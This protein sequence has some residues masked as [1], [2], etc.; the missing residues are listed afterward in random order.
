MFPPRERSMERTPARGTSLKSTHS[1]LAG[2]P[3]KAPAVGRRVRA[4]EAP[5]ASAWYTGP[6]CARARDRFPRHSCLEP[7]L[8]RL[9]RSFQLSRLTSSYMT[10]I[11]EA[12]LVL[13]EGF[14]MK[15][16]SGLKSGLPSSA[17]TGVIKRSGTRVKP[18]RIA[19][20]TIRL[21]VLWAAAR[22]FGAKL[23][24]VLGCEVMK[25]WKI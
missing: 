22:R 19:R 2:A 9:A 24:S 16:T 25:F 1:S 21:H 7:D 23:L 11:S 10:L 18:T 17:Y 6:T 14:G 12:I 15:T 5:P 4:P 3:I 20:T 13:F 8:I